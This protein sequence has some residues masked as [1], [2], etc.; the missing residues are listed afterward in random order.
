MG[1][2]VN[3]GR[4]GEAAGD[5]CAR[6]VLCAFT[7]GDELDGRSHKTIEQTRATQQSAMSVFI[8][9]NVKLLPKLVTLTCTTLLT[10]FTKKVS[11]IFSLL[12]IVFE[13]L[14]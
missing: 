7:A 8:P 2:H 9:Q 11:H 12:T 1:D 13:C 3:G 4:L 14:M 10:K 5:T 6:T